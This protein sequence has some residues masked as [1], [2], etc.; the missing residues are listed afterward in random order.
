MSIYGRE[1]GDEYAVSW[2]EG[3]GVTCACFAHGCCRE[4][5]IVLGMVYH[6]VGWWSLLMM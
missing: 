4:V 3:Q 1:G 5:E 2:A 6:F